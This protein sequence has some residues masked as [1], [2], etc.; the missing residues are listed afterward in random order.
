MKELI[1]RCVMFVSE[2]SAADDLGVRLVENDLVEV[3]LLVSDHVSVHLASVDQLSTQLVSLR[4]LVAVEAVDDLAAVLEAVPVEP[5]Q[6]ERNV[7]VLLVIILRATV[8]RGARLDGTTLL[9]VRQ[10]ILLRELA[11]DYS[12]K[13]NN[14]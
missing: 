1:Y 3:L 9:H 4:A 2:L 11:H 13:K 7:L 10:G 5:V 8:L 6:I 12:F 14:R